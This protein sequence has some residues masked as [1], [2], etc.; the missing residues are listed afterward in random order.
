MKRCV[1]VTPC[2]EVD[3]WIRR[4]TEAALT[5]NL[6]PVICKGQPLSP[7]GPDDNRIILSSNPALL[8][9]AA[10]AE[11]TVILTHVE[12]VLAATTDLM[13]AKGRDAI[14]DASKVLV[15]A[16]ALPNARL[17]TD[18][19]VDEA[20]GAIEILSGVLI[21]P[22]ERCAYE[23]SSDVERAGLEALL[24]YAQGAPPIGAI[25]NWGPSLFLYDPRRRDQRVV[26][27]RL[28]MT[29]GPRSFVHGPDMAL[30]PGRWKVVARFSLDPAGS[31]HRFVAEWGLSDD[32]SSFNLQTNRSG[33][34]EITM[35]H[36]WT[37]PGT[38]ELRIRLMEGCISG[39]FEFFGATLQ[40]LDPVNQNASPEAR[41]LIS[42]S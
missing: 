5:A 13:G 7:V 28:D 14:V 29:G 24:V 1:L 10:D 19:V 38:V 12:S 15:A 9:P 27:Q 42:G 3:E 26:E 20:G 8:S 33:V 25:V 37:R 32:F 41:S 31:I 34:F 16:V 18:K 40:R 22:P 36:E 4:I 17:L 39:E 23:P 30:P 2:M 21:D 35:A 11:V 6:E